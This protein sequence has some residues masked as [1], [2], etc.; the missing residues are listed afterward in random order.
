MNPRISE[1]VS[2]ILGKASHNTF[3]LYYRVVRKYYVIHLLKFFSEKTISDLQKAKLEALC[4]IGILVKSVCHSL[5]CLPKFFE[6]L[7]TL[8]NTLNYIVSCL[9]KASQ[10]LAVSRRV[11][12]FFFLSFTSCGKIRKTSHLK[13]FAP[14]GAKTSLSRFTIQL[15]KTL[16]FYYSAVVKVFSENCVPS[17]I[18]VPVCQFSIHW[19]TWKSQNEIGKKSEKFWTHSLNTAKSLWWIDFGGM[20]RNPHIFGT[21]EK[22][23]NIGIRHLSS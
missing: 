6:A 23:K 4:K 9:V 11:Y 17:L 22:P 10:G 7:L 3:P 16:N 20:K 18:A 1:K 12:L 5:K 8:W 21:F 15:S 2:W 14:D 19:Q 13:I